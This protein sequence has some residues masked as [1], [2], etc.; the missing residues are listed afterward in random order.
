MKLCYHLAPIVK[1]MALSAVSCYNLGS[2]SAVPSGT[3]GVAST[4]GARRTLLEE[5]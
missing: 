1:Y 4:V 3:V 5:F 2:S